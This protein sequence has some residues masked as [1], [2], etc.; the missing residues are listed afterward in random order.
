MPSG[1]PSSTNNA[2]RSGSG[3][4]S[5]VSTFELFV[6]DGKNGTVEPV[7]GEQM[8]SGTA[9]AAKTEIGKLRTETGRR[10]SR[11]STRKWELV[12]A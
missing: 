2:S 3:K 9:A 8:S 5:A 1:I 4:A 7:S 11:F 6:W 10:N 12:G